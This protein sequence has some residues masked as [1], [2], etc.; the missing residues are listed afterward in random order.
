M[1]DSWH[2]MQR[3]LGS[4]CRH[5]HHDSLQS[6]FD[7]VLP[8]LVCAAGLLDLTTVTTT[9]TTT[10]HSDGAQDQAWPEAEGLNLQVHTF[11]LSIQSSLTSDVC[12][13]PLLFPECLPSLSYSSGISSSITPPR[14]ASFPDLAVGS[15]FLRVSHHY[16]R[17]HLH[18]RDAPLFGVATRARCVCALH[19]AVYVPPTL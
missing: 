9:T 3:A 4:G 14:K 16:T 7:P 10:V 19:E 13:A 5:R 18:C 6:L 8:Q 1:G 17:A 15:G 12:R 2:K 11:R